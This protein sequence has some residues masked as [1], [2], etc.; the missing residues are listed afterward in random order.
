MLVYEFVKFGWYFRNG[1]FRRL[2]KYDEEY[3]RVSL[4]VVGM[5]DN[6]YKKIGS[7]FGG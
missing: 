5:W 7:L 6:C 2:I 4:E 1:W 3:I